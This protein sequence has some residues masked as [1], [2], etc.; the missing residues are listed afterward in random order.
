M[1]THAL[2]R[3]STVVQEAETTGVWYGIN[4][5]SYVTST[6]T[7]FH[8]GGAGTVD[9]AHRRG[10]ETARGDRAQRR[11]RQGSRGLRR[12]VVPAMGGRS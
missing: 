3:I 6:P 12:S 7:S 9:L 11:S 8:L 5:W 4:G 2:T 10:G 1:E